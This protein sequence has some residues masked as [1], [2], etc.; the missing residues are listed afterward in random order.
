[1]WVT[2]S[3]S[4]AFG[5]LRLSSVKVESMPPPSATPGNAARAAFAMSSTVGFSGSLGAR[6]PGFEIG[7]A[8]DNNRIDL[9]VARALRPLAT[10]LKRRYSA[11]ASSGTTISRTIFAPAVSLNCRIARKLRDT[12]ALP[13]IGMTDEEAWLQRTQ[14]VNGG[15]R[16]LDLVIGQRHAELRHAK[17]KVLA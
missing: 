12:P 4:A 15:R 7:G 1:M 2:K 13:H 5:R 3:N 16:R 8:G 9:Q 17:R 11:S 14:G 10:D 6:L